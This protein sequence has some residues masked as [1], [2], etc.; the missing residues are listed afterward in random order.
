MN[1]LT[2]G[3]PVTA[4]SPASQIS[5]FRTG[6]GAANAYPR[7][8]PVVINEIM[9]RPPPNGT[10]DN[11]LDEFI[12]LLNI[13]GASV[14]LYDPDHRTNVWR[15]G[16]GV[17]FNFTTNHVLPPGGFLIVVSFDPATNAA[18]LAAFRSIYG[19]NGII[20]GPWSGKLANG[21]EA[22]E[23][24]APDKPE[25]PGPDFGLVPY[26]TMDRVVYSS[27]SPW[28]AGA[29]GTGMSLQRVSYTAYGNDPANWIAASPTAGRT[30][31]ISLADSDADSLPDT[32]EMAWFGT[33][34][35]NG[36]GDFDADG[37]TDL[38]EFLA[39]TNPKDATD[40][41]HI[42]SVSKTTNGLKILFHAAGNRTYSVLYSTGS[43]AGP[44]HKLADAPVS[45]NPASVEITD[46]NL[47]DG[48]RFYRLVAP[49][50]LNP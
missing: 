3:T 10:N 11:L 42:L 8:G 43:P 28:P 29:D 13:T 41:F 14:P 39:G 33:L 40:Y 22:I 6:G 38:Q 30:N 2:F 35:R 49:A 12:E 50:S 48:S 44:W 37:M 24:Q 31:S 26:V 27:A 18:A 21:G 32:W 19:T 47:G 15:L 34:A 46:T 23:L 5:V 16:D 7:V 1:A 20:A 4:Q 9:Y 25:P 17:D 36:A 45:S